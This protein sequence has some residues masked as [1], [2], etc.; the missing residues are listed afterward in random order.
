MLGGYPV[1]LETPIEIFEIL[2]GEPLGLS[3]LHKETGL[4]FD[5]FLCV[6][7]AHKFGSKTYF[8]NSRLKHP[9][10]SYEIDIGILIEKKLKSLF[11]LLKLLLIITHYRT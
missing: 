2:F 3:E 7:F 6:Y 4:L 5:S 1:I 11:L 9:F 10:S 8:V